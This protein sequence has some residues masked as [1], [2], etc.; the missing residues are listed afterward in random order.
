MFCNTTKIESNE[1]VLNRY[2]ILI[3]TFSTY[4]NAKD[5]TVIVDIAE[6]L[7]TYVYCFILPYFRATV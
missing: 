5:V 3:T 1:I 6:A 2:K 4:A 7:S